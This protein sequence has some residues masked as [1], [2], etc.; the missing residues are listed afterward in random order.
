M[1]LSQAKSGSLVRVK[2]LLG[3]QRAVTRLRE[4]G[5]VEGAVIKVIDNP[6]IGPIIIEVNGTR[7]ALG[8]G[9]ARKVIVE[10]VGPI[11][12]T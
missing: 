3:G 8:R 1:Y 12:G 6:I 4:L 9:M 2:E 7:I 11:R 5:L 10:P